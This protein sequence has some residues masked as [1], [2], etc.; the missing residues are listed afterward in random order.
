MNNACYVTQLAYLYTRPRL[1]YQFSIDNKGLIIS[2]N[3]KSYPGHHFEP[4]YCIVNR[5]NSRVQLLRTKQRV[6]GSAG[7]LAAVAEPFGSPP[8][9][10]LSNL[11]QPKDYDYLYPAPASFHFGPHLIHLLSPQPLANNIFF[12]FLIS[13][14]SC[15]LPQTSPHHFLP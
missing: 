6:L 3:R 11:S 7:M 5:F 8:P 13:I 15:R 9:T 4:V 10:H 12:Y 14:K 1:F 2:L